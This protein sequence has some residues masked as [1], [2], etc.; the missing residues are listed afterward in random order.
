MSYMNKKILMVLRW[1][2]E[3][4]KGVFTVRGVYLVE[5][6]AQAFHLR[7]HACNDGCTLNY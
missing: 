5:I 4:L 1:Y 7:V 3:T 6:G 2:L